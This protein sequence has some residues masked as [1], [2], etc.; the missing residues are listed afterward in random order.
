MR[1]FVALAA[2]ALLAVS[3]AP[4]AA[5]GG[6]HGSFAATA[7]P[8]PNYSSHTETA[9]PGCLAGVDGVHNVSEPFTAPG[10]GVL[11]A[12]M[13]GFTGDWDLYLTDDSGAPLLGSAQDQTAGAAAEESVELALKPKQTVNITPCNW[14]GAPEAEVHWEFV[15]KKA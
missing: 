15:S 3:V 11:K 8:F 6:K 2:T 10:K 13:S 4:A 9:E 5:A 1:R 14:A 7:L 12:T